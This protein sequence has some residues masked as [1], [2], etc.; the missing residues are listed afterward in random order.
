MTIQ[1]AM[2][3]AIE[4]GY[5]QYRLDNFSWSVQAQYFLDTSFW[6]ALGK[7]LGW[8][9]ERYEYC[10]LCDIN[11]PEWLSRFHDF[12]DHLALDKTPES[13]FERLS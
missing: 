4:G 2:H 8:K 3:K 9:T 6:Q 12:I 5:P 1:E 10:R 11:R 7:V 13:F